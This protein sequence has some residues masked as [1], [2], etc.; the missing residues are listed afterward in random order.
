MTMRGKKEF[1]AKLGRLHGNSVKDAARRTLFVGADMIKAEAQQSITRGSVSGKNHVPSAPGEPPNNDTAHLKNNIET[2]MPGPLTAE[3]RS[4]ADYAAAL[5][6]GT[7]KMAARP[8]MRPARDK[9]E[10][11]IQR[12][13]V[14]ELQ[15]QN[16]SLVKE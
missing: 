8:Y 2:S 10:P 14:Q 7:S 5:E 9:M 11:K 16:Q 15:K 6:L 12:L 1:L 4:N 13:F 3:V